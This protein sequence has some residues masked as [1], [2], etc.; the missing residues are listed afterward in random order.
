MRSHCIRGFIA[1]MSAI[2]ISAI[3]LLSISASGFISFNSRFN[4]VNTELK[5]RSL[6][7]AEACVERAKLQIALDP[8]Y[9]GNET[10]NA[11]GGVCTIRSVTASSTER[12]ILTQAVVRNAYSNIRAVIDANTFAVVSWIELP[13]I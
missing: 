11:S 12:I 6:S 2:V 7:A 4:I 3:L 9:S 5:A 1:L 10:M 13:T 8:A